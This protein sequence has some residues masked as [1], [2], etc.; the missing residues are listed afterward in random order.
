MLKPFDRQKPD[1]CKDENAA[2][3]QFI[4]AVAKRYRI[5]PIDVYCIAR[6]DSKEQALEHIDN[7]KAFNIDLRNSDPAELIDLSVYHYN[8]TALLQSF[9]RL[10]SDTM[11]CWEQSRGYPYMSLWY[12]HPS[13]L[14]SLRTFVWLQDEFRDQAYNLAAARLNARSPLGAY[15]DSVSSQNSCTTEPTKLQNLLVWIEA[16]YPDHLGLYPLT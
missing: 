12:E 14:D 10:I 8:K 7:L 4:A 16:E 9:S 15:I 2:A 5:E 1:E 6:S 13:R 11:R 3:E